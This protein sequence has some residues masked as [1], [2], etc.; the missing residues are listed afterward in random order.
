MNEPKITVIIPTRDRCDVLGASLR[1]VTAQEYDNLEIIVSDNFSTDNTK[2]VVRSANDVRIKYINTGERISMSHNW[3]FALSN[4]DDT[5][6]V[7]IIGD[8]DGLLPGALNKIA[9]IVTS[10]NIQAIRTSVCS[11]AWPSLQGTQFRQL[12]IPLRSGQELRKSRIWLEKVLS[13]VAPYTQ[14]PML[15]NGGFV[16]MS[17]LQKI[18]SRCGSVYNSSNP[19]IYSA[20]AIAS[21]IDRYI[22]SEEPAAING[23]S[24]HSTGTSHFSRKDKSVISP[25]H[26]F[27]SENNIPFHEDIPLSDCGRIPKSLQVMVYESYLQ[28]MCL[29]TSPHR[30][31]HAEQLEIILKTSRKHQG[32]IEKWGARF[33]SMHELD[34]GLIRARARRKRIFFTLAWSKS[35]IASE[36][37]NYGVGSL[38][39]PIKDVYEASIVAAEI[40]ANI[41]GSAKRLR[42]FIGRAIQESLKVLYSFKKTKKAMRENL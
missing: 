12:R 8:D 19:D 3:E 4:V 26:K 34:Y 16:K 5:G 7:T 1:T 30:D 2:E 38:D 41:P 10:T 20:V 21:V 39:Q 32:E 28:S 18:K 11:Y 29:R 13:G 33:A 37:N 17:V 25:A 35:L 40:T 6:W 23:A 31:F 15:Y 36:V 14:L 27:A 9:N 24:Q 22:Y 42:E